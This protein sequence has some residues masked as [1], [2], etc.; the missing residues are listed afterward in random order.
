MQRNLSVGR[1]AAAL[2]LVVLS[3]I[4]CV[5]PLLPGLPLVLAGVYAYVLGT[6]LS[7]GIGRASARRTHRLLVEPFIEGRKCSKWW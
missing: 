1:F 7:G 4:G 5:V 2:L 3:I 6:G